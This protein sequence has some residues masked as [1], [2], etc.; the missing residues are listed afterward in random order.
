M[1]YNLL[2]EAWL[3]VRR[4]MGGLEKIPPWRITCD[5]GRND[6]VVAICSPRP[7][8]DGGLLEFLIGLV[9]TC[10]TP[11]RDPDWL[12][13][14]DAPPKPEKL[15]VA[16]KAKAHAFNL[17][18]DGP[19]FM[20]DLTMDREQKPINNPVESLLID[21][22]GVAEMFIRP[23]G[24]RALCR[25]CAAAAL[26]SLQ[27]FAPAGGRGNLTSLRG[28]GPL[29]TLVQGETLW[30]TVWNN[31]LPR[32]ELEKTCDPAQPEA[33]GVFPWLVSAHSG[34]ETHQ[35]H[36]HPLHM[37]WAMPRRIRLDFEDEPGAVCGL[38]GCE[39]SRMVREFRSRPQG[40][41][42]KG[43]WCHP[44]TPY[45][46]MDK[47]E[48][49]SVKGSVEGVGYRHWLGYVY[50]EHGDDLFRNPVLPAQAVRVYAARAAKDGEFEF[51]LLLSGYD[52]DKMKALGWLQGESPAW[53]VEDAN[54]RE[55]FFGLA[56]RL[57]RGA[58]LFA[59]NLAGA[60]K[61]AVRHEKAAAPKAGATL[62]ASARADFWARTEGP[63]YDLLRE[64]LGRI[65]A[66]EEV[67]SLL[68]ERWRLYLQRQAEAVFE[69]VAGSGAFNTGEAKRFAEALRRLRAYCS[70][71]NKLVRGILDLPEPQ[72][73]T[74]SEAV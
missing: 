15:R 69:D 11:E 59:D 33:W 58:V 51:R 57:V 40:N 41:D 3:P 54:Q 9:Q 27:T 29:T 46:H 34:Q 47:G 28:G 13:L 63:F 35:Q 12:R 49:L 74:Q 48:R 31:V 37:F 8:L 14:R 42:Y 36:V 52:M 21:V 50:G 61:Q 26:Y 23:G 44:L 55:E 32:A 2:E 16:F 70:A 62:L 38:C 64:A 56:R 20:Q 67:D 39:D 7:D 22:S 19:R 17:D 60:L 4:L 6:P 53:A 24:L 10:L 5:A 25:P 43:A 1:S 72:S 30:R 18:G 66:G 65:R 45:R 71:R 73:Q 68:R